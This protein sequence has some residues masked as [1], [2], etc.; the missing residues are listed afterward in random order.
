MASL[1]TVEYRTNQIFYLY[2]RRFFSLFIPLVG[3]A[4]VQD[5]SQVWKKRLHQLF[6]CAAG[7]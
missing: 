7:S 2:E 5:S 6:M 1:C 3:L 4:Y